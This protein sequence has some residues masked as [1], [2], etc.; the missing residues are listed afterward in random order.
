[1]TYYYH[2]HELHLSGNNRP[3]FE[4][5]LANNIERQMRLGGVH[6]IQLRKLNGRHYV[7]APLDEAALVS[8]V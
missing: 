8:A 4:N 5:L 6:V 1:V 2:P 7:T 3:Q